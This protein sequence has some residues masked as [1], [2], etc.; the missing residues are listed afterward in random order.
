M[1]TASE[2]EVWLQKARAMAPLVERYRD[3]CERERQ[4]CPPLFEALHNAGLMNLWL[5][6]SLGGTEVNIETLLLVVEELSRQDGAAGWNTMIACESSAFA[7]FLPEAGA[8]TVFDN[9]KNVLGGSLQPKGQAIAVEGGYRISG[10]WPMASG[11]DHTDWLAGGCLIMDAGHPRMLPSGMPDML[12]GL[13]PRAETKIIDTWFTAGLRGTGSKDIAVEDLFV[14][15]ERTFQ[16]FTTHAAH[17]GSTYGGLVAQIFALPVAVVALGIARDAID[18]FV[19]IALS[20][21]PQRQLTA[22]GERDTTRALVGRAEAKL[23]SARAFLLDVAHQ[24]TQTTIEN[25]QITPEVAAL[26]PLA[27]AHAAETGSEVVDM[28][29]KASGATGIYS[30]NRLER[31]FR[32]VN[33]VTQHV[34]T[35]SANFEHGGRYFLQPAM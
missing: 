17:P 20:K 16:M 26:I 25:G 23:R 8:R 14:P 11:C 32:D 4:M 29:F 27:A 1:T 31:R 24:M 18:S 5:P 21:T 19:R 34:T 35:N 28:M 15:A 9:P 12:V 7:A 10:Q 6:R 13:F 2:P 22:L 30:T 3:E 33:M